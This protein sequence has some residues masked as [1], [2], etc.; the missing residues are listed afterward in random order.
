MF[1]ILTEPTS[2]KY[3]LQFL[4]KKYIKRLLFYKT[5][6]PNSVV[7]SILKWLSLLPEIKYNHNPKEQDIAPIVYVPVGLETLKFALELKRNWKIKK[8]I[9]GPNISVPTSW[10]DI[11]F[12]PLIDRII[13]PSDWVR[14]Y[15]LSLIGATEK[16]IIVIPAWV[17]EHSAWTRDGFLLIY[18]KDCPDELFDSIVKYLIWRKIL[19]KTIE[20]GKF[21][22]SEYLELLNT[23]KGLIYLQNSESQWIALH[24]AWMRNVPALVWN[25]GYCEYQ[26]TKW[27]DMKISAPYLNDECGMFFDSS[28]FISS[29][30]LFLERLSVYSPR[31]Y[32]LKHFTNKVTTEL[33]LQNIQ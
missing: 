9:A 11:F 15:F 2:W 20:Y 16:R 1:T 21:Q 28:N 32:S 19:Y 12:H 30:S 8:L 13:V 14:N 7:E 6:W 29:F 24:E 17:D 27:Y 22:K 23:A 3:R 5:F 33:L 31:E 18:K 4:I 26:Q 25:R 10:N